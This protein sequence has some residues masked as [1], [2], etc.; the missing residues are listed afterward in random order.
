MRGRD[1]EDPNLPESHLLAYEVNVDLDVLRAPVLN[2]VCC[3][4]DSTH[5][6]TIDSRG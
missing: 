2:R 4:V 5:I 1:V 6:V 3:H